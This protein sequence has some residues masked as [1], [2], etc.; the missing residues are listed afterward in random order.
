METVVFFYGRKKPEC[1]EKD[2]SEEE[3]NQ[4][5]TQPIRG[6]DAGSWNLAMLGAWHSHCLYCAIPVPQTCAVCSWIWSSVFLTPQKLP[7]LPQIKTKS[8]KMK[9][10]VSQTVPRRENF[11]LVSTR[12]FMD[13]KLSNSN[14]RLDV[15]KYK[16]LSRKDFMHD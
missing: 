4:H 5:Q 13:G 11:F 7:K 1:A 9:R 15:L 10:T 3:E 12:L 16:F 14:S 6:V 8:V 2:L